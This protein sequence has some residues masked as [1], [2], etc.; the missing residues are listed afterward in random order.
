MQM[1]VVKRTLYS[2]VAALA[3]TGVVTV[4]LRVAELTETF[5]SGALPAMDS[6]DGG[7]A[8]RPGLTLLHIVPGFIFM[9]LGPLQFVTTIRSR[10]INLHRWCGR[11]YVAS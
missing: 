7:F 3:I 1:Q 8:R 9:V 6:Y 2:V 11:I 10:Y 4:L 5:L